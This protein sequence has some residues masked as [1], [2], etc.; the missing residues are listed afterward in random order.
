MERY[1]TYICAYKPSI[2]S[3]FDGS[4]NSGGADIGADGGLSTGVDALNS[5]CGLII[6]SPIFLDFFFFF[7]YKWVEDFFLYKYLVWYLWNFEITT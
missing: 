4:D 2:P 5:L 3:I 1:Y 6:G 7:L